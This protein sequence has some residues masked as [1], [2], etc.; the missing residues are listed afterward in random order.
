MKY[1]YR[2]EEE[3]DIDVGRSYSSGRGPLIKGERMQIALVRK[4]KGSGAR[5]HHHPNEQFHYVIQGKLKAMVE[6]Q[7]ALVG[8]GEVIHIPPNAIHATVA[9]PEEDVVFFTVKDLAWG[10]EGIPD[11]GKDTGAYYEPGYEPGSDKK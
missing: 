2:W 6:G 9:T 3:E 1:F 7:E 8:P 4:A 5:P 11:D 10:I